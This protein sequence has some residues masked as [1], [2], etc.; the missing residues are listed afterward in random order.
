M[1]EPNQRS[2]LNRRV[3]ALDGLRGFAAL[4]VMMYHFT[5]QV[6]NARQLPTIVLKSVFS[7]GWSGVDLFF[8]LSGF[9]ITSLLVD[10]KGSTNYFRVFYGRRM[11]RILPLYYAALALLFLVP[12]VVRLPA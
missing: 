4:F 1:T 12:V 3:P 10:A 6:E 7:V 11:L 5:M 8:V 9:L 2:E